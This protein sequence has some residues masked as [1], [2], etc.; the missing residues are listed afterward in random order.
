MPE[1]QVE[2]R[3]GLVRQ[4]FEVARDA[5][6]VGAVERQVEAVTGLPA[7]VFGDT[8]WTHAALCHA[9][10]IPTVVFGPGGTGAHALE[11]WVELGDV[12]R[13]ADV[14]E[15]TAWELCA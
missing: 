4:P 10:G 5:G 8:P 12:V 15:A 11:E 7:G 1:L 9:A 6:V 2:L 13:C 14:L 3:P